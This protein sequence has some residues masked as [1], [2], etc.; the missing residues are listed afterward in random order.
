MTTR[1]LDTARGVLSAHTGTLH[2][3]LAYARPLAYDGWLTVHSADGAYQLTLRAGRVIAARHGLVTGDAAFLAV[4][5]ADGDFTLMMGDTHAER[6]NLT[7]TDE[8]L[9]LLAAVDLDHLSLTLIVDLGAVLHATDRVPGPHVPDQDLDVLDFA[10]GLCALRE[11]QAELDLDDRTFQ[12]S[13]TRLV[14]EG[15]LVLRRAPDVRVPAARLEAYLHDL[16][17]LTQPAARTLYQRS[18]QG[19]HPEPL[20]RECEET[21]RVIA[22]KLPEEQRARHLQ[23]A[24]RLLHTPRSGGHS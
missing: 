20:A 14:R 12:A 10:S 9:L 13:V 6:P 8:E 22:G 3:L 11:V 18:A 2:T 19:I 5:R 7:S 16:E 15:L 17:G 1:T 21:V 24:R 4:T 23:M